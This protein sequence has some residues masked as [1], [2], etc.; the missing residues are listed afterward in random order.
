MLAFPCFPAPTPILKSL[1]RRT[2][3]RVMIKYIK[4]NLSDLCNFAHGTVPMEMT[5]FHSL[6]LSADMKYMKIILWWCALATGTI[7]IYSCQFWQFFRWGN[8]NQANNV[9]IVLNW[10]AI[11]LS[12]DHVG[13]LCGSVALQRLS[14]DTEDFCQNLDRKKMYEFRRSDNMLK[15]YR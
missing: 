3:F 7:C 6:Y 1:Y 12:I 15:T 13:L 5:L 2:E 14:T 9:L 11:Y 8:R 4:K 10:S